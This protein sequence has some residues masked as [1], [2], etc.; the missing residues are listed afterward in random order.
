MAVSGNTNYA[1]YAN[2]TLDITDKLALT[3]GLRHN[4]QKIDYTFINYFKNLHFGD[5]NQEWSTTGKGGIEYK[6]TPDI[7]TFATYSTGYKGQA[8]DLVS[9]FNAKEAAQMPVPHETAK[10]YEVGLKSSLFDRRVYFDLTLF[11]ATYHG[12]Q[13][14]VTSTLPDGSFL[15]YL[16]SIGVLKTRGVEIDAAAKATANFTLNGS[17]AYTQATVVSFPNGPCYSNQTPVSLVPVAQGCYLDKTN[18]KVQ[19]L[20]GQP[21]NNVPKAKGDIGG[22]YDHPLGGLPFGGF[23]GFDWRYQSKVNFSLSQDPRTI[24]GGYGIANFS[25][26]VNDNHDHY[27]AR[28]FVENAFNKPY[29]TGLTQG[30]AGF[31]ATAVVTGWNIPRDGFRYFGGRVDVQ[32]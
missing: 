25:V 22:E 12:F 14:S 21:L 30:T 2:A 7:M 11:S 26:G 32:F 18:S 1:A 16:Q 24:Q 28:L 17:F 29:A 3:G 27:K 20:A 15:T 23:V 19:N 13:T 4:L 6:W 5:H 10:N 31:G 8:Y 9:V